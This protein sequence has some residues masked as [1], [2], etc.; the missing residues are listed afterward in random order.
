MHCSKG[1]LETAHVCSSCAPKIQRVCV[2]CKED[3]EIQNEQ[4]EC[5]NCS[6][7]ENWHPAAE[8]RIRQQKCNTCGTKAILGQSGTCHPCHVKS[9][10]FAQG[11]GWEIFE[12][13]RCGQHTHNDDMCDTCLRNQRICGKDG[14]KAKF[15]PYHFDDRFCDKHKPRCKGCRIEIIYDDKTALCSYCVKKQE[16]GTCT[17]CGKSTYDEFSDVF[18]HCFDCANSFK[19]K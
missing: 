12:C 15:V 17:Y 1:K 2:K 16:A 7:S 13:T 4:L 18:G 5:L 10:L 14:C 6:L 3:V 11:M 19:Q 9:Q 8:T